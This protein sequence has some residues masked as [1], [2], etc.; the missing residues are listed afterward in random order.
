MQ[1]FR[2]PTSGYAKEKKKRNELSEQKCEHS[3]A[4]QD[5]TNA[6]FSSTFL[7]FPL[8]FLS[9]APSPYSIITMSGTN[10]SPPFFFILFLLPFKADSLPWAALLARS[11]GYQWPRY[12]NPFSDRAEIM[13]NALRGIEQQP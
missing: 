9:P 3:A 8:L 6:S 7:V 5:S 11:L 1:C 12:L 13:I 10:T 4:K 2:A